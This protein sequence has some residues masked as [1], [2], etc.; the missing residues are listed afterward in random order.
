[1]QPP[2]PQNKP[3]EGNNVSLWADGWGRKNIPSHALHREKG[4]FKTVSYFIL[5]IFT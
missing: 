2:Y 4:K 3:W 1:M 5:N